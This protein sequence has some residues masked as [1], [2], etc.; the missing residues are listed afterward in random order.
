MFD[1]FTREVPSACC[2][3]CAFWGSLVDTAIC[4]AAHREQLPEASA[5]SLRYP[6]HSM[7]FDNR[8]AR[9]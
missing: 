8:K 9:R 7:T 1:R 6:W 3:F 4:S 2:W 5:A